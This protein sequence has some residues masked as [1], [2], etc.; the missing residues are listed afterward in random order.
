MADMAATQGRLDNGTANQ[1]S[2]LDE[3]A[4]AAAGHVAHGIIDVIFSV[5][6]AAVPSSPLPLPPP[7]TQARSKPAVQSELVQVS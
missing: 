6:A 7:Q 1:P 2:L 3:A 5:H 4:N